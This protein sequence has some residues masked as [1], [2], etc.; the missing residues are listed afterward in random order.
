MAHPRS[1]LLAALLV[2]AALPVVVP[3]RADASGDPSTRL[4][5]VLD[6][7]AGIGA[8]R[9]T[10]ATV[11]DDLERLDIV[12]V[13]ASAAEADRL[14]ASDAVAAVSIDHPV[15]VALTSSVPYVGGTAAHAAGFSG[16]GTWVAVIDTGVDTAHPTFAGAPVVE[17]CFAPSSGSCPNGGGTQ[18]GPGSAQPGAC[19]RCA[20]GTHVAGIA[21]GR[22]AL[23]VGE[24]MAPAAGL[25]AIQVFDRPATGAPAAS[26][27][28]VLQGLEHVAG[29]AASLPIAAVNVSIT[30]SAAPQAGPCNAALPAVA[31][32]VDH[33]AGA[34]VMTVAASG[35]DGSASGISF[36]AC[37]A[38]IVSVGSVDRAAG[39]T[40]E[41][42]S[43]Y[44]NTGPNLDLLAPGSAI[45]SS[46]PGGGSAD[47]SGTSMATPH[48]SG[49]V[50]LYRACRP[51]T[52]LSQVARVL[53]S[54]GALRSYPGRGAFR[55]L[56]AAAFTKAMGDG[57]GLRSGGTLHEVAC[58]TGT[59]PVRSVPVVP[60]GK[61]LV[62]DWNGDGIDT[63]ARWS[64]RVFSLTNR[65]DGQGPF[66]TVTYGLAT[67]TP[68]VGDWDGNGT[69]TI[70]IRRGNAYYLRNTNT[71]GIAH[72]SFGY[73]TATDTPIVGDWD[74]NGTDTPGVR[75]GNKIHLRNSN[76]SGV[77][78]LSFGYGTAT[79][80]AIVGDWDGNGTDTPGVRRGS[81]FHLRNSN[82]SGPAQVSFDQGIAGDIPVVGDWD[83]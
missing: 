11:V 16:A 55:R 40:V 9:Q 17:A 78:H 21:V 38:D 52:P 72:L 45:R 14:R 71:S 48:V 20:H 77:A 23:G 35:N 30:F 44:S 39:A 58:Q 64:A 5:V 12:I 82:T 50:A 65:T 83:G 62:G 80:T 43:S 49:A 19:S 67:D 54:S 75:R 33:L 59:G 18:Q 76:T 2:T 32:A 28:T 25:I 31:A 51:A 15:E 74:A 70:G 4:L 34:G 79:D 47:M 61:L 24:G 22:G 66:T 42:V 3:A 10:G 60:G 29:L 26:E 57:V 37:L 8:V 7:G 36:P 27:S 6:D 81:T 41:K 56:D 53:R 13:D 68:V 1:T 63:I 46:V 69:D 73:G